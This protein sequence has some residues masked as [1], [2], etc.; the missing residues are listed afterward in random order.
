MKIIDEK[1]RLFGKINVIDFSVILFL[2]CFTPMFYFGYKLFNKKTSIPEVQ[3]EFF[4]EIEIDFEFIKV[5]PDILKLIAVGDKEIN[6]SDGVIGEITWIGK[7]IPHQ[8][9]FNIDSGSAIIKEDTELKDI[10]VRLKLKAEMKNASLYYKDKQIAS[11]S[12]IDFKTV[13][14]TLDAIVENKKVLYNK[15]MDLYIIL[16][17]LTEDKLKLIAVG[18]KEIDEN[19]ET[20]AEILKIGKIENNTYDFNLGAGNV[21]IGEDVNTQQM[22][23]KMRLCCG[24][25][26]DDRKIRF[27]GQEIQYDS[28]LEFNM[29]KYSVEGKI[30]NTL[31]NEKW[32]EVKIRF[33]GVIP[34]LAKAI[35]EGDTEKDLT[36]RLVGRLKTLISNKPSET[37][38]LVLEQNKFVSIPQPFMRDIESILNLLCIEKGGILY[39]KN[40]PVKMGNM[41]TFT[42]DL[43][44]IQGVIIGLESG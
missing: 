44:S 35:A 7:S 23:V 4:I 31:I 2:F 5:K 16:K 1:G 41:I 27:K 15:N 11:T 39:F 9:K 32:A 8:Y 17:N 10:P 29:G 18:D 28:L 38:A 22:S 3:K 26:N 20:I 40:N 12:Q 6:G 34:E 24:I 42:T 14:Y 33:S 30:A 36:G 21:A 43:Y 13:K 19:G 25:A 37:Q